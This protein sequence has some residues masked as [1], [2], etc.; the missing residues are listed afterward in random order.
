MNTHCENCNLANLTPD[1]LRNVIVAKEELSPVLT[2][3][4]ISAPLIARSAKA[5]QFVIVYMGE[6]GERIPLT[7]SD[8]DPEKGTVTIIFQ[9][10][11]KSTLELGTYNVG[12]V[13]EG[14][15][16]PLGKPTDVE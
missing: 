11:G 8:S 16:V 10:V 14:I 12:D 15:V 5:G 3:L 2:S 1:S 6:G 13:I 9:K 4:E 7:V